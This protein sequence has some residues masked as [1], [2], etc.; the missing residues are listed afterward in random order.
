ML[1]HKTL[2]VIIDNFEADSNGC[3][4]LIHGFLHSEKCTILNVN[5]AP[6]IH[7]SIFTTITD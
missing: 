4:V 5:A 1:I 2:P 6:D 3:Y 7:P